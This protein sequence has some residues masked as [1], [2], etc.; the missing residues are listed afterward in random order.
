[1]IWV[2]GEYRDEEIKAVTLEAL[3]AGRVLAEALGAEL[4]LI[5]P[6]RGLEPLAEGLLGMADKVYLLEHALLATYTNDAYRKAL[7]D[8]LKDKT[9]RALI[10]PGTSTG[11]D[12]APL[13]S[14]SLALP[15]LPNATGLE[16][17]EGVIYITRPLYGGKVIE[18]LSLRDET[19]LSLMPRAFKAAPVGKRHGEMIKVEVR[20]KEDDIRVKPKETVRV[21]ER[22]DITEADVVVSGG[23]GMGGPEN[24]SLLEELA[25]ILG[26]VVGA[27]RA[28]VDA[29]W[30]PHA[31]QV[32]Q[33]G[34][35]V[36]PKLYIACG[37]SGA[38]QHI[39]GMRTSRY[40]LAIN[41][42]PDAPIFRMADYGIVGDLFEVIPE[43][44]KKI[45]RIKGGG[46]GSLKQ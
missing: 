29:G 11:R 22:V 14:V 6:G 7:E 21:T 44:I 18:T 39:V 23:R 35:V 19:I 43:L 41:K 26:G 31:V 28:A 25:D 13:L 2:L 46:V 3:G 45:K 9:V 4:S 8:F 33:T 16:V 10:V 34:R 32:G 15:Y 40:V 20:L 38:P 17:K 37:I 1:M 24:F 12:L 42:D 30:M 36:S 27:S 5:L